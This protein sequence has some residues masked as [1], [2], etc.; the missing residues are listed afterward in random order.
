M[1]RRLTPYREMAYH[2]LVRRYGKS[3]DWNC[4]YAEIAEV[5]KVPIVRVRAICVRKGYPVS[6]DAQM[7]VAYMPVDK[8]FALPFSI[9]RN[10]Y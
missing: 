8:Y 2:F 5:T 1:R 3:V 10:L 6:H 4:S 9:V 7:P